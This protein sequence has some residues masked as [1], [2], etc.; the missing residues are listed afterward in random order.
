MNQGTK[1]LS[2]VALLCASFAANATLVYNLTPTSDRDAWD[3]NGDGIIDTLQAE[4]ATD[5][6]VANQASPS[7]SGDTSRAGMEFQLGNPLPQPRIV[8]AT[9]Y[10]RIAGSFSLA[11]E[12][13]KFQMQ[14]H[15]Y[16][17]DGSVSLSDLLVN[18]PFLSPTY[19][20]SFVFPADPQ[21]PYNFAMDVKPALLGLSPSDN[22]LGIV[23]EGTSPSGGFSFFSRESTRGLSPLL[24]I[25][26]AVPEPGT[27]A[28]L[29]L[30][31]LGLGLSRRRKTH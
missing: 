29:G 10:L 25:V 15:S 22:Y 21:W 20:D 19:W 3:S 6:Y 27:L 14:A 28:L 18:D 17:G 7:F 26:V 16:A 11:T 31:I 24:R 30:G 4:S 1:L 13:N 12:A 23:L 2:T 5:L 8:S 9:L